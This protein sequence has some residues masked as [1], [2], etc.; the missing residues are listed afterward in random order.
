VFLKPVVNLA[1]LGLPKV[2][3]TGVKESFNQLPVTILSRAAGF[4]A[5]RT[6]PYTIKVTHYY[7]LAGNS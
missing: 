4:K 6:M 5:L 1:I 3:V 2:D 7:D